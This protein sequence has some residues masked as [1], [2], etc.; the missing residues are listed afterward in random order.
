MITY[1]NNP[2]EQIVD[3]F[4]SLYGNQLNNQCPT[5]INIQIDVYEIDCIPQGMQETVTLWRDGIDNP[6]QCWPKVDTPLK[7]VLIYRRDVRNQLNIQ[8][9]EMMALLAHEVGHYIYQYSSPIPNMDEEH[10]CDDIA[11]KV[12]LKDELKRAL[13]KLRPI[14]SGKTLNDLN[15]RINLL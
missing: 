8:N 15:I 13:V 12:G 3:D 2:N 10:F 5:G 6:S 4:F 11:V 9:D 14:C 1:T 7:D